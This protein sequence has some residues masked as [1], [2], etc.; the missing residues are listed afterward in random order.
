MIE[1]TDDRKGKGRSLRSSPRAGKPSAWR[2][3][4]VDTASRQEADECPAL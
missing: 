4:V 2:R 3:Q 1:A